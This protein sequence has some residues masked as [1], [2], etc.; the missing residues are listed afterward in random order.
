MRR[1][2][3]LVASRDGFDFLAE[4]LA[5]R[6]RTIEFDDQ[7]GHDIQRISHVDERFGR[8]NCRLIHHLH[9][10]WNDAGGDDISNALSGAFDRWETD[11]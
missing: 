5:L 3:C 6:F 9:A 2:D 10:R 4:M 11:Q 1:L 8:V 7:Q